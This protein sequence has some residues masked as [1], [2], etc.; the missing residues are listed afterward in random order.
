MLKDLFNQLLPCCE[1][2][3]NGATNKVELN[4]YVK[5][6]KVPSKGG[7]TLRIDIRFKEKEIGEY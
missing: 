4:R 1:M 3:I 5:A 2:I 6:Y 7:Y